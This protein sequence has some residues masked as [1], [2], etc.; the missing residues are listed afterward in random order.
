MTVTD[1]PWCVAKVMCNNCNH[2]M[3]SVYPAGYDFEKEECTKCGAKD[4]TLIEGIG[5]TF[6]GARR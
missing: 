2:V 1:G 4:A 6:G 3:V 5:K